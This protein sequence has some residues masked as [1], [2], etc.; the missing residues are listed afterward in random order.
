MVGK[1]GMGPGSEGGGD[2]CHYPGVH[3]GSGDELIPEANIVLRY[4][5]LCDNSLEYHGRGKDG[6]GWGNA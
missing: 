4:L 5:G 2:G 1:D 6:G 3:Q